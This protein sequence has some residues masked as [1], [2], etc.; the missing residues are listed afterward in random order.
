MVTRKETSIV[1]MVRSD[2]QLHRHTLI[3]AQWIKRW[4]GNREVMGSSPTAGIF[5]LLE[6]CCFCNIYIVLYILFVY[7]CK[8]LKYDK[9][10]VP[11]LWQ[12]EMTMKNCRE[13][14]AYPIVKSL[15]HLYYFQ[16]SAT[17]KICLFWLFFLSAFSL[18]I[19]CLSCRIYILKTYIFY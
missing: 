1:A 14:R 8:N 16:Y 18:F 2:N 12:T 5:F 17:K 9:I 19:E 7:F 4:T 6:K 13:N 3:L 10:W 15:V 11:N